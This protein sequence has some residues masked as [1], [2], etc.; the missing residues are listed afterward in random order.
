MVF[1]VVCVVDEGRVVSNRHDESCSAFLSKAPER[2]WWS[3]HRE[4]E[5]FMA[6]V[7]IDGW[8]DLVEKCKEARKAARNNKVL[9]MLIGG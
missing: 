7:S 6:T 3:F 2:K 1:V 8:S 5:D 4:L 9:G